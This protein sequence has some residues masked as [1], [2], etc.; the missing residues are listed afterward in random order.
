MKI[1]D[2]PEKRWNYFMKHFAAF[3]LT[4]GDCQQTLWKLKKELAVSSRKR[5]AALLR[6]E[7]AEA[8]VAKFTRELQ[9]KDRE[10]YDL[11]QYITRLKQR[12]EDIQHQQQKLLNSPTRKKKSR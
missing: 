10:H 4:A 2:T 12:I 3:Q 8:L 7:K 1:T 11:D 9:V 6:K 5:D